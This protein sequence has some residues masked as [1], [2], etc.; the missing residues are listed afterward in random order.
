[1]DLPPEDSKKENVNQPKFD[2]LTKS[3]LQTALSILGKKR[4]TCSEN[5]HNGLF[6]KTVNHDKTFG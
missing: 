5:E 6:K 2:E 4:P 3:L 1:M